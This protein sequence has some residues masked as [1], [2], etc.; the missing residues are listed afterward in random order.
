MAIGNIDHISDGRIHGWLFA[1]DA[2]TRPYITVNG[3][4]ARIEAVNVPRTDVERALGV[5]GAYGFFAE[6]PGSCHGTASI[7]LYAVDVDRVRFVKAR[8]MDV[9]HNDGFSPLDLEAALAT[10]REPG[11]VAI[12]VWDAAHNPAGRAKV[13]YDIV[14]SRRPAVLFGFCHDEFGTGLWEP[15]QSSAIKTCLIRPESFER[16]KGEARAIGLSFDTVWMCKPRLPTFALTEVLSHPRTALILDIDD[17]EEAFSR[18]SGSWGRW[19]GETSINKAA[20]YRDRISIRS[21]ASVSLQERFGGEIVR[22]ARS[23]LDGPEAGGPAAARPAPGSAERQGEALRVVFIGTVRPHKGLLEAARAIRMIAFQ[24]KVPVTLTVGGTFSPPGL[25]DELVGAGVETIGM[26]PSADLTRTL[27][28]YDVVLTGYP[29]SAGSQDINTY[30]I[31]SKI[32]DALQVGLPVLVPRSPA[33][34]DLEGIPGV[35]LF[36]VDSFE[37][38]LVELA[39]NPRPAPDLPD[40]FSLPA[41]YR[42]FVRL[43]QEARALASKN[44]LRPSPPSDGRRNIVLLW[45]QHDSGLYGRRVDQIARVLAERVKDACVRVV[46]FGE[47]RALAVQ[48]TAAMSTSAEALCVGDTRRKLSGIVQNGVHYHSI[49]AEDRHGEDASGPAFGFAE[50][51]DAF[52][53]SHQICAANSIVIAFPLH[54]LG[55]VVDDLLPIFRRFQTIVDVVDNQLSWSARTLW[56]ERIARYRTLCDLAHSV[57]FNS[58]NNQESMLKSSI[59]E[60]SKLRLIPNW[61]LPPKTRAPLDELWCSRAS[62][63]IHVLYSGDLNNRI[64][65]DLLDAVAAQI[66]S[67]GGMLHIVGASERVSKDLEHLLR[68]P[69][70]I[71]HGPMREEAV[72]AIAE[73]CRFAVVPHIL[74]DLS[75]LMNPLKIRMYAAVGLPHVVTDV[76]GLDRGSD[77][78]IV[79][80]DHDQFLA[81][82]RE[83]LSRND[84]PHR[85]IPPAPAFPPEAAAYC[86]VV[87]AVFETVRQRYELRPPRLPQMEPVELFSVIEEPVA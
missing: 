84:D 54:Y 76:P 59:V 66:G 49:I 32:G 73:M 41:A 34:L 38:V 27:A 85:R 57:I 64:D 62:D 86:A 26:V 51:F 6:M 28:Q 18:G 77:L 31:S 23:R 69:H 10:A 65:W 14:A 39:K 2:L 35:H 5:E 30:Q 70:C 56:P 13:L 83:L 46:E 7:E 71:Y 43:E 16:F 74:N 36:E 61:Y 33:T 68:R 47:P 9:C 50:A 42:T 48:N 79:A 24:R 55:A 80:Q 40:S 22:H 21:V 20:L 58:I 1:E 3:Q 19:Y 72:L 25:E 8:Q 78:T 17:N 87:E 15:L 82:V 53:H 29:G 4:P 37:T 63:E 60:E 75:A 67:R 11:S 44:R 81:H 52:L 45:K 12:V